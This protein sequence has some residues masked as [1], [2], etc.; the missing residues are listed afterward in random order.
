MCT[1][2]STSTNVLIY[3]YLLYL[4]TST[5]ICVLIVLNKPPE[6]HTLR[7]QEPS[8]LIKNS[9]CI[10]Y[11]VIY[12]PY[13]INLATYTQDVFGHLFCSS[14]GYQIFRLK[15]YYKMLTQCSAQD[16]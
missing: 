3:V 9:A 2:C 16:I 8:K 12:K 13:T 11:H 10:H 14:H 6:P 15:C 4:S 1:Y 7:N 5:H